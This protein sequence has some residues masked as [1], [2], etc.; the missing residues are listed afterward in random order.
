MV[1]RSIMLK[2]VRAA[3]PVLALGVGLGSSL[4]IAPAASAQ[5]DGLVAYYDRSAGQSETIPAILSS[6]E[7]E[8]YRDLF[9]AIID[10]QQHAIEHLE[11]YVKEQGGR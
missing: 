5:S 4:A 3:L 9:A 1:G 11:H 8:H 7:R 2:G 10:E 6:G